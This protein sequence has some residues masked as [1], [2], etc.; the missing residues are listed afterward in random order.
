M[1]ATQVATPSNCG[2][3]LKPLVTKLVPNR[4]S[5]KVSNLGTVTALE[6]RAMDNPHPSPV[7]ARYGEGSET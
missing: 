3:L 4:I 6:D 2:K 1:L 7:A 5:G